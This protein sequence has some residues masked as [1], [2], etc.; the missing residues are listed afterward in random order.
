MQCIYEIIKI[1]LK[2]P[3]SKKIYKLITIDQNVS[4]FAEF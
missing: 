2:H 4:K 1:V 3:I